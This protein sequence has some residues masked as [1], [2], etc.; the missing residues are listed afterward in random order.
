MLGSAERTTDVKA[1]LAALPIEQA[2]AL[3]LVDALGYGVDE[4]A[5]ILGAPT[6]TVKSRCARGRARLAVVLGH[7]GP[8]RNQTPSGSV[9]QSTTT[10]NGEEEVS[11]W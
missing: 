1:A 5:R 8:E 2:A 10:T 9:G 7:L 4:A 3:V 6:G 11:P